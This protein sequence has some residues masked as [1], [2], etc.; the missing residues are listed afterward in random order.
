MKLNELKTIIRTN[1]DIEHARTMQRFFK[2][3]KGEYGEGDK[4]LGLRVPV[5]R[6][7]ANR[8]S[9][10]GFDDLQ[11]LLNSKIHEERLISLLILIA[12]Y[13]KADDLKKERIFNLYTKNSK[14][15]NNWDLVDLSAPKIAGAHLLNNDKEILFKFAGSK[16]IWER[17]ISVISTFTFIKNKKYDVTLKI[18]DILLNDD[19]DLIHK[20]IGWM[21]REVGKNDLKTLESF[22]KPR[23]FKMPRTMLRYAIEKFPETKRQKYLKGKV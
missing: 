18:T 14:K 7:I 10:L 16:N 15:V 3:G 1:A 19:Q 8:F 9:D 11:K 13:K 5:Q 22:L 6:K 2:T 17:R 12:Q 20:A 21:L 4:F 23:Y